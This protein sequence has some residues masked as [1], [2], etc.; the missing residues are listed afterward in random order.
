MKRWFP[1]IVL[2]LSLLAFVLEHLRYE[3]YLDA[4]TDSSRYNDPLRIGLFAFLA[5]PLGLGLLWYCWRPSMACRERAGAPRQRAGT[6][7]LAASCLAWAALTIHGITDAWVAATPVP[8][9]AYWLSK[10]AAKHDL[11]QLVLWV[12]GMLGLWL[13]G[14][15]MPS[16]ETSKDT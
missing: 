12:G 16:V 14:V 3:A 6:L 4:W 7:L 11:A 13:K 2:G 9:P 10:S 8:N 1:I 5:L 15:R